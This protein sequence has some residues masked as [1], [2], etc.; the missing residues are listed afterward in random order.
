MYFDIP[1]GVLKHSFLTRCVLALEGLQLLRGEGGHSRGLPGSPSRRIYLSLCRIYR[2]DPEPQPGWG[3]G[4]AAKSLQPLRWSPRAASPPPDPPPSPHTTAPSPKGSCQVRGGRTGPHPLAGRAHPGRNR[5]PR[6][7]PLAATREGSES[8]G[9]PS[10]SPRREA[11]PLTS[12]GAR[13]SHSCRQRWGE[14][15]ERGGTVAKAPRR[16]RPRLPTPLGGAGP[17]RGRT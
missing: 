14:R 5:R 16:R 8:R 10:G 13:G 17:G 2:P 7:A 6:Q 3:G 11:A 4:G 15:R 9:R 1:A 12:S